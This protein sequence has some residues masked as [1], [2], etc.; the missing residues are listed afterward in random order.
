MTQYV[1]KFRCEYCGDERDS[2][3]QGEE[4][5]FV[6]CQSKECQQKRD[7]EHYL[8]MEQRKRVRRNS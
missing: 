2:Y 7:Q 1:P 5:V 3:V 8:R 6:P 4:G